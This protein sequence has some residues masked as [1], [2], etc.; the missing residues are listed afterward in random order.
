MH[1]RLSGL[2]RSDLF[3]IRAH[4]EQDRPNAARQVVNAI[5]A[6]AYQLES[7]PLLGRIGRVEGTRELSVPRLPFVIVYTLPDAYHV[8]SERVLHGA[9][10]WPP[11]SAN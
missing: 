4:I 8:E 9:M 5:L 6:T 10:L 2:A 11:E 3:Q 1:V 7:F